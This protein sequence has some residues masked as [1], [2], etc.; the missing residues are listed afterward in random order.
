MGARTSVTERLG[1]EETAV[2]SF[3]A[4]MQVSL[5]WATVAV[6]ILLV[7]VLVVFLTVAAGTVTFAALDFVATA[8]LMTLNEVVKVLV[9]LPAV[10][11]DA[12]IAF[13]LDLL[14][15]SIVLADGYTNYKY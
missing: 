1:T 10:V 7:V 2:V 9:L 6:V 11:W 15:V 4:R 3:F 13:A 12:A 5:D 8:S 14:L